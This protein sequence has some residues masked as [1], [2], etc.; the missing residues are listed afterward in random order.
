[1]KKKKILWLVAI[2]IAGGLWYAFRPELLFVNQSV[3][4]EFPAAAPQATSTSATN[5]GPA[6]LVSGMFHSNA[7]ETKGTASIYKLADGKRLLR[8]TNFETSNGPD[9]NIYLVAAPDVKDD[10]TVKQA[11]FV[12]LGPIKGNMGDQNYEIPENVDLARYQA[13]TVW[14]KRFSVNFGTAPLS[15]KGET[16]EAPGPK[17]LVSGAFH[18]GAHETKGKAA[19]YQL[20]DGKRIL[21]FTEFETSNGPDV[22]V[23]LVA[24]PDAK[25]DATVK[26]AGFVTL[27]PIKGNKGDQNYELPPDVDLGKYQSVT[28][29]CKRFSVN[30]GTAPLAQATQPQAQ[31]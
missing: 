21:R 4:E 14:C 11:G 12:T 7:H 18:S 30:F 28:V 8:F 25:D 22:N 6:L 27:G 24:A 9:V 23:Y 13:V 1:M 19:I 5:P 16:A 3:N 10:G 29:W 20:P 17:I 2:V 26:K 15:M 31:M